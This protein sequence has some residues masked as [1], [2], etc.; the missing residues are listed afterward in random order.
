MQK[1]TINIDQLV[2]QHCVTAN[3]YPD[4]AFLLRRGRGRVVRLSTW[5]QDQSFH[6]KGDKWVSQEDLQVFQSAIPGWRQD[7]LNLSVSC[8]NFSFVLFIS[9]RH[10]ET[11]A[12]AQ[13]L[14]EQA[15][16]VSFLFLSRSLS[17][18]NA[19]RDF[20]SFQWPVWGG[21]DDLPR[22]ANS[23]WTF[24]FLEHNYFWTFTHAVRVLNML[25]KTPYVRFLRDLTG[26]NV[27]DSMKHVRVQSEAILSFL[28]NGENRIISAAMR[29]WKEW[30]DLAPWNCAGELWAG[31]CITV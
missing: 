26:D 17:K 3:R 20:K 13:T 19:G 18:L 2:I 6:Q 25:V 10:Q 5:A 7:I 28:T 23:L 8:F 12:G 1:V 27:K 11:D 14:S 29:R 24:L 15:M 21:Q 9:A 4:L 30:C 22:N 16:A 31:C